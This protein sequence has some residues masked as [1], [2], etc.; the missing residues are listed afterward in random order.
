MVY[1]NLLLIL[2]I[3]GVGSVGMNSFIV[4]KRVFSFIL[5]FYKNK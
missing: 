1:R 2:W 3:N 5:I 4:F